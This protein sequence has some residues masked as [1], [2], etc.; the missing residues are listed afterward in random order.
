MTL[1]EL[2]QL[3]R[4]HL[5][6]L[7]LVTLAFGV[8]AGAYAYLLMA[9]EY[10]S[11]TSVY[12]L[13]DSEDSTTLYTELNTSSLITND[14]AEIMQGNRVANEAAA[15]L[16]LEDLEGFEVSVEISDSSRIIDV[17]VT[18][19]DPELAAQVATQI[20]E[21]ATAIAT[22]AMGIDAITV[23]EEAE[24]PEEP[25]G[26]NRPLY[27]AVGLFAGFFLDVAA[28]IVVDMLNTK[29]RGDE[30]LEELTGVPVLG[31]VPYV[32]GGVFVAR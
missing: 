2:V 31:R 15:A 9:D 28:V 18:G 22:D 11:Q 20:V 3:L 29:I 8:V 4:K 14:V 26:P 13:T 10:T 19:T 25:S 6:P 17:A 7:V 12:V 24:V 1:L 21:S 27:V 5:T 30:E 16:G 23:I 32:E